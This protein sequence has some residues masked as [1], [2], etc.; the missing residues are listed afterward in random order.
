MVIILTLF[1][2]VGGS[3]GSIVGNSSISAS[4][5]DSLSAVFYS[6]DSLGNPSHADSVFVL[7]FGP[8]GSVVWRDSLDTSDGRIVS[9][10]I[11][12]RQFYCFG[13]QVSEIDGDGVVGSYGLSIIA[14]RDIDGLLTPNSLS[15]QIVEGGLSTSLAAIG[16][17]VDIG[18]WVWDI[19][20]AEHTLSG[21]FGKYLDAEVSGIGSGGGA[22]AFTI[23]VYDSADGTGL[24]QVGLAVR[25]IDQ[26]TLVAAGRSD[27]AGQAVFNL[28]PDSFLVVASA[29]G[30]FF[31]RADTVVV[32]GPGTDTVFASQF[33]PGTPALPTFCRVWGYLFSADGVPASGVS[34]SAYLPGGV[35]T[36]GWAIIAPTSIRTTTDA[37]GYFHLD[38]LPSDS[39]GSKGSPY[40]LSINRRDGAILRKRIYVPDSATWRLSW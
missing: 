18:R 2:L 31:E 25:T 26:T 6:L 38:L 5:E 39:L 9:T 40:E 23:Q 4:G 8:G 10:T 20:Q 21:S 7:V 15:F 1:C 22:I 14:K 35:T 11:Q 29:P 12:G 16:D 3:E 37:S 34:V 28:E 32:D 27:N 36:Y 19:P 33:D 17:S 24:S 30:Y 13:E